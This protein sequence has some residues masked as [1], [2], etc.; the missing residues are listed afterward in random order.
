MINNFVKLVSAVA[1]CELAGIIGAV[2][3]VSSIP[4]WYAQLPKPALTP[5]A[6]VF[7][8]AWTLLFALMGI[9]AYLVLA[10]KRGRKETGI[11]L[12]IFSV[13]LALNILWS[14][15][16][17]GTRNPGAAFIEIIF[18]WFAIAATIVAFAR[19]SVAAAW[20]LAPY[21]LWV[22]FAGY[23]NYSI[24]RLAA[25]PAP[26]ACTQEAKLCPDGSSVGRAG[27][28]CE[29]APCPTQASCA[30]ETCPVPVTNDN[31]KTFT[32]NKTGISF[33]Y[34]EDFG[35]KYISTVDWPPTAAVSQSIFSC[36]EAGSEIAPAGAT[37][38]KKIDN[39][40]YC[41]TRESEGAAGSV[42][43]QYVYAFP[44]DQA[45]LPLAADKTIILTF[46]LRFVQ[47]ANYDDP[48]KTECENERASFSPDGV[49]DEVARSLTFGGAR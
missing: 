27:I 39:R 26:A 31:L 13:Q 15:I 14:L 21:I 35:T 9:A 41:V 43:A 1:V 8:P 33:K 46:S 11:A 18:L 22:S 7:G 28:N 3:T 29:F 44:G 34:P 36:T 5:L 19:V 37:Q 17:F 49:I 16:F 20:F 6:W 4:T 23:L 47:C 24:W 30:G 10:K 25:L 42:Y 45:S 12:G 38:K 32:D 2:F 40:E 48:Q